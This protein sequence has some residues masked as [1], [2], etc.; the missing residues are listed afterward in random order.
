MS[1]KI[2]QFNQ[3]TTRNNND[4]LL[5]EEASTGTYKRIKVSDFLAGLSSGSGTTPTPSGD[6]H[7]NN[8]V[9]LMHFN[10]ANDSVVFTDVKGKTVTPFGNARISTTQSK[11][12]GSSAYFDGSGDYLSITGN[13]D[14]NLNG[15]FTIEFFARFDS[16]PT[17]GGGFQCIFDIGGYYQG[18][19]I[20][21]FNYQGHKLL[22]DGAVGDN[23]FPASL[24]SNTWYHI[25]A[26]RSGNTLRA[27]LDGSQVGSVTTLANINPAAGVRIGG[28]FQSAD[29]S[30]NGYIDELRVTKGVVRYTSAFTPPTQTFPNN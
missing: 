10:G 13:D 22:V 25:A 26:T 21:W 4:W 6:P 7:F 15:D 12:D 14:F 3:I 9:L 17:A 28:T 5:I 24:S 27:F 29:Q 11:F 16:V 23:W 30:F 18:I 2:S 20:G 1:K 8:V 19:R